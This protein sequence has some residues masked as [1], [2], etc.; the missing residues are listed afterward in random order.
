MAYTKSTGNE[1]SA[2]ALLKLWGT[3]KKEKL[4]YESGLERTYSGTQKQ[5]LT[6]WS[7]L[8]GELIGEVFEAMKKRAFEL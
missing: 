5:I 8:Y 3:L 2:D 7:A 1:P 4:L 6:D